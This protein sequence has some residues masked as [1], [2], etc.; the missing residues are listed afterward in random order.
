MTACAG[1]FGYPFFGFAFSASLGAVWMLG[2]LPNSFAKRR[3][4]IPPGQ[5]GKGIFALVQYLADTFDSVIAVVVFLAFF[6]D[7]AFTFVLSVVA[8]GG[9]NHAILDTACYALGIK[10][11]DFP[12]PLVI[13]FQLLTWLFFRVVHFFQG[14]GKAL[15]IEIEP[16]T[17]NILIS[18]HVSKL[19]PFLV[20]TSLDFRTTCRLIPYRFMV[21]KSY[22]DRFF[23]NIGLRL[24]GGYPA[25]AFD[26]SGKNQTLRISKRFLERGETVYI[27]PEGGIRQQKFG[28]GAFYLNRDI[29]NSRIRLFRIDKT[30]KS[31]KIRYVGS[32]DIRNYDP[33]ADL[34]ENGKKM[35]SKILIETPS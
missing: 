28:V 5:N 9:L 11:L 18:N 1:I 8:I 25:H 7:F 26:D 30:R 4:G 32:D 23:T 2:E 6:H 27:F 3:L 22:T 10:K 19:D 29:E 20:C 14:N 13:F 17:R 21:S 35:F 24:V 33:N 12:N 16:G 31:L 34:L 15:R